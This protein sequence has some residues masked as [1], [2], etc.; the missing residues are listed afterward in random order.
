MVDGNGREVRRPEAEG[1]SKV[2]TL[3]VE[4]R[5]QWAVD[6]VVYFPDEVIRKRIS[7]CR[8]LRLAAITADLIKRAAERDIRT[9]RYGHG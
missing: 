1:S 3:I 7:T 5:G 8:T 4:E 6:I 9:P 2:E